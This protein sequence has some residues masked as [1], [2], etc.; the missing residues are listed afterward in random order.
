MSEDKIT[1]GFSYGVL[2]PSLEEQAKEQGFT[3]NE[4]AKNLE[5]CREAIHT[6][7]FSDILTDSALDKAFQKLQKRVINSLKRIE[8]DESR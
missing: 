4:R 6:L 5:S 2:A 7:V 8:N 3:L 1:V